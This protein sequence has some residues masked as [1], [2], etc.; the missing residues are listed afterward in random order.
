M[1]HLIVF[2]FGLVSRW[3]YLG[4]VALMAMESSIVP[5]PSEVVIPP[6]AYWASQGQMNFWGVIVAGTIGSW[7][8]AALTWWISLK[9][10][11]IV[12][13][14]WGRYFLISEAK[15]ERAE[16]FI[17]RYESGGIFF[18]RLLPVVRHLISI[19]AGLIHM[20]FGVFSVMTIT[21]SFIW[22]TI[23]AWLGRKIGESQPGVINDPTA[24][25]AAIKAQ[26]GLIVASVVGLCVLYVLVIWMTG[27]KRAEA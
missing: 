18:A 17:H 3:G 11:R 23:L 7:I 20:S 13:V 26:S 2:W 16:R 4:I 8:G 25:V 10:G 21:G 1:H 19:P 27:S 5:V 9:L 22:C 6:A 12:V 24:M 14:K 15:L